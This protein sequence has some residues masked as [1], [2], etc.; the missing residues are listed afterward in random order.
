[1]APIRKSLRG[2][3]RRF[4]HPGCRGP[5]ERRGGHPAR[6]GHDLDEAVEIATVGGDERERLGDR[7]ELDQAEPV[8]DACDPARRPG[9]TDDPVLAADHRQQR[10]DP[11]D[12]GRLARDQEEERPGLGF[13][14]ALDHRAF[15]VAD[16]AGGELGVEPAG[17]GRADRGEVEQQKAR[18]AQRAR[19]LE[20]GFLARQ[21]GQEDVGLA[22]EL[23]E[24]RGERQVRRPL[25]GAHAPLVAVEHRHRK[26]GQ[27]QPA[28]DRGAHRPEPEETQPLVS[29]RSLPPGTALRPPRGPALPLRPCAGR[30]VGMRRR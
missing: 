29:H 13:R 28:G 1:L 3:G 19:H 7:R 22:L 30:A 2:L 6:G 23:L 12:V 25:E 18:T 24:I 16:A 15:D 5:E 20:H 26:A 8:L 21:A 11:L 9:A 4:A 10:A 14:A 17:G 27:R